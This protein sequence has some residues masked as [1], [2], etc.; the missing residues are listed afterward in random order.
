MTFAGVHSD[1]VVIFLQ[2]VK[3]APKGYQ[4]RVRPAGHGWIDGP[5]RLENSMPITSPSP[6]R[7]ET[8]EKMYTLEIVVILNPLQDKSG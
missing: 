5:G 2:S 8:T 1:H 3:T 4:T 7:K 6:A